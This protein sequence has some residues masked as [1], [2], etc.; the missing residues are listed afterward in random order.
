MISDGQR[1]WE[2]VATREGGVDRNFLNYTNLSAL[3]GSPPARVAWIETK[4]QDELDDVCAQVATREGGVD[5]NMI[6]LVG[7]QRP[8]VAT[9]EGGVDRNVLYH[10]RPRLS[11]WSPPARVAWI[12][13]IRCSQPFRPLPV[14]TREGG[15]DRNDIC[16]SERCECVKSPPARV[17][18]IETLQ[19]E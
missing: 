6:R 13:T 3:S 10:L 12:E 8:Q 1:F 5:R 4:D 15:V 14:A 19:A 2:H 17:A 18:W 11:K 16:T 9:R 7:V